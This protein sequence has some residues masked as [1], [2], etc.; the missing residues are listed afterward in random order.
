MKPTTSIIFFI[1]F[2]IFVAIPPVLV[3]Q[4]GYSDWLVPN[5]WVFYGFISGLTLLILGAILWVQRKNSDYYAQIFLAGT[6]VKILAC[7]IFIFVFVAK[8]KVNKYAFVGDFFYLYLLN[9]AF[10]VYV[11]LRNLRHKNSG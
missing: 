6:T 9:M 10:E 4:L 3:E 5:F 11:L 8:N 7:L 1:G 2:I